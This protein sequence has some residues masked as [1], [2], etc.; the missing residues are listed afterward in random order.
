M[1]ESKELGNPCLR[2]E[3]YASMRLKTNSIAFCDY[4]IEITEKKSLVSK[5]E[6]SI[7]SVLFS[8]KDPCNLTN[9]IR[10]DSHETDDDITLSLS[11]KLYPIFKRVLDKFEEKGYLIYPYSH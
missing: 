11:T 2:K 3:I 9:N 7:D 5:M 8:L 10:L 1:D 4:V 6:L